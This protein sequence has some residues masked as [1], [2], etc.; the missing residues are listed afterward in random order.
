[1]YKRRG[2]KVNGDKDKVIVVSEE[3]MRCRIMLDGGQL[4]QVS[5]FKY[6]GFMLNEKLVGDSVC[7]KKVAGAMN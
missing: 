5:E 7:G 4:G 3:N 6:L 2:L 1:M